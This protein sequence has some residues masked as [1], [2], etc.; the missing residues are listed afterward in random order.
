MLKKDILKDDSKTLI[1]KWWMCVF[2]VSVTRE[3]WKVW[4]FYLKKCA[5]VL[6][7]T[8]LLIY[9]QTSQVAWLTG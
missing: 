3:C 9:L 6:Y 8:I 7:G 5:L 1:E 4:K 2:A